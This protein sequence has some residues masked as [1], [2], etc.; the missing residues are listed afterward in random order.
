MIKIGIITLFPE[1]FSNLNIGL[2]GK[3]LKN[4]KAKV[5]FENLRD[6]G[7]GVHKVIDDTPYGGGDGMLIKAEPVEK[8]LKSLVN[9]MDED[10]ENTRK[11]YMCPSG[12][13]WTQGR[14]EKLSLELS[15]ASQSLVILCGRYGGVDERV[16]Q[17][18]FKE[19]ISMGPY[20]LNGGE[21]AA[22]CMIETLFRLLPGVL[23]NPDSQVWDSFSK[24]SGL[25]A[26]SYTKPRVWS[27]EEVPEVLLSGDHK[28]IKEYRG[29]SSQEKTRLW[30]EKAT[31]EILSIN[32]ELD[33]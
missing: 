20:I 24:G 21:T 15:G 4:N 7:E 26:P 10:I 29:R 13:L 8:A 33:R 32:E 3:A 27:D 23:G 14:A 6:H 12:D 22:L 9:K 1:A 30:K 11:I 17:K 2:T 19:R 16:L 18:H 5:F 25:E 31:K 28:K